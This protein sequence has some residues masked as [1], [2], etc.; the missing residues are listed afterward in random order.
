[1]NAIGAPVTFRSNVTRID[2]RMMERPMHTAV[3]RAIAA[4]HERYYEPITLTEL[5]AEVFVSPFHFSRIFAKATGV[6]P[7]RYLTAVRMFEAKRLLLTSSLTVSDIVCTVGYSSVGT[8]TSRFT[9]AVGMT[10]SQYREPQVNDLLVAVA[11]HF[12]RLP[13]LEALREAGRG[14]AGKPRGHASITAR[15]DLPGDL[16]PGNL[17][18]GVFAEK[19]PQCGPVSFTGLQRTPSATVT[20]ENVPPG[21]WLVLAAAEHPA[22]GGGTT[23]SFGSLRQSVTITGDE[24]VPVR[25]RTHALQPIDPPIA[26]TLAGRPQEL[27]SPGASRAIAPRRLAVA[28]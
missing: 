16:A 12:Q 1:M 23:L 9:R 10:P 20:L 26:I 18:V 13:S 4:M 11:P 17:L 27:T 15:I 19:I 21:R 25:V 2:S 7:G 3:R 6:T 28:A 8:F 14:C 5:A 24:S 22:P